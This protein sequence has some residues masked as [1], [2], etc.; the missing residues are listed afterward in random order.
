MARSRFC[1]SSIFVSVFSDS[2]A[3]LMAAFVLTV[4]AAVPSKFEVAPFILVCVLTVSCESADHSS[5]TE[6][7]RVYSK[8]TIR[9]FMHEFNFDGQVRVISRNRL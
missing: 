4:S 1:S 7:G 8:P 3:T 9:P 5:I 6:H 2:I